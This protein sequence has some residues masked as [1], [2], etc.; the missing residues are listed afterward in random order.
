MHRIVDCAGKL[1]IEIEK[2]K[3]E[4]FYELYKNDSPCAEYFKETYDELSRLDEH[5]C[6]HLNNLSDLSEND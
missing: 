1:L 3:K 2:L 6:E 4:I 5:I